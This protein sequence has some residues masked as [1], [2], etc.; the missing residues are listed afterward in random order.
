VQVDTNYQESLTTP[1]F[2]KI[3]T[4][5]NKH[6]S[7]RFLLHIKQ[8]LIRFVLWILERQIV[9]SLEGASI[10]LKGQRQTMFFV[11]LDCIQSKLP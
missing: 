4:L 8:R 11:N 9:L 6:Y 1:P 3:P 7:S 5:D 2:I 10:S